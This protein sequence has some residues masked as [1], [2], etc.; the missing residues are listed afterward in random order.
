MRTALEAKTL[1]SG[2][3]PGRRPRGGLDPRPGEIST[4][5]CRHFKVIHAPFDD[6]ETFE[7]SC[8]FPSSEVAGCRFLSRGQ[9]G[10]EGDEAALPADTAQRVGGAGGHAAAGGGA[11]HGVAHEP[12]RRFQQAPVVQLSGGSTPGVPLPYDA[13]RVGRGTRQ[14]SDRH[15]P[16]PK[17]WRRR[18]WLVGFLSS[19][20]G[21]QRLL[22]R[23]SKLIRE[24][25]N[26]RFYRHITP[27]LDDG[28]AAD[29]GTPVGSCVRSSSHCA[30]CSFFTYSITW[31]IINPLAINPWL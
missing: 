20:R 11:Q 4:R 13:R 21:S 24:C 18:G 1:L 5:R 19:A 26:R 14:L 29:R 3:R 25:C 30:Y 10:G 27:S 15:A 6:P 7:R 31:D 22:A 8:C 16:I 9:Q 12:G 28:N 17:A 23:A 2:S